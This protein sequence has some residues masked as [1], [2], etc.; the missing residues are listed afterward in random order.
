M[1]I[2]LLTVLVIQAAAQEIEPV[3]TVIDTVASVDTVLFEPGDRFRGV[4][5]VTAEANFEKHLSQNP[6]IGMFKSML[7]PGWGQVGNGDWFK[8]LLFAGVDAWFVLNALKYGSDAGDLFDQ[9]EAT[10]GDNIAERNRLYDLYSDKRDQRNK[11]T[12]FAVFATLASMLDA[13]VDAHLSGYPSKQL[14][15]RTTLSVEPEYRDETIQ[16]TLALRF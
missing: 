14:G 11:Y 6:T 8:A 5:P 3:D 16:A 12:W 2:G 13:Y 4:A 1:V 15:E 7:V 9:Y 10:P